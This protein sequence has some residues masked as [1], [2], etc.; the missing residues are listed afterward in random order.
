[1][2]E[3]NFKQLNDMEVEKNP[4]TVSDIMRKNFP[5]REKEGLRKWSINVQV[6]QELENFIFSDMKGGMS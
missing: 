1:M 5:R 6:Q 2:P 4:R 3:N